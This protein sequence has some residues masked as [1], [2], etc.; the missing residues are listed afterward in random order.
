MLD[1]LGFGSLAWVILKNRPRSFRVYLELFNV[2]AGGGQVKDFLITA[3]TL[4][5]HISSKPLIRS[6]ITLDSETGMYPSG[7]GFGEKNP[8]SLFSPE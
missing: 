3:V 8:H 5:R 7:V 6:D 4:S 1:F 2:V